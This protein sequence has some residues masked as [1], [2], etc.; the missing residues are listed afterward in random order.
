M[1]IF[2]DR[3]A[4]ITTSIGTGAVILGA[5]VLS[6]RSW[7]AGYPDSEVYYGIVDEATGD[8]EVGE[9][10]LSG[11][12]STLSRDVVLA[13]STGGGL[14]SFVAGDKVVYSPDPAIS[15]DLDQGLY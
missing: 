1:S 3:V 14:V 9:G 11:T 6:Y 15:K 2:A 10:T 8:W 5:A 7:A 12:G 13:S 4:V